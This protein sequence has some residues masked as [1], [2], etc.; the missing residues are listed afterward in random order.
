MGFFCNKIMCAD[1]TVLVTNNRNREDLEIHLFIAMNMAVEYC[2]MN[3]LVFSDTKEYN[4][5]NLGIMR[6]GVFIFPNIECIE[7]SK[8][9][10]IEI[11]R[12]L[13]WVEHL[14]SLCSKLSVTYLPLEEARTSDHSSRQDYFSTLFESHLRFGIVL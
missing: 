7:A 4:K 3:D 5:L 14:D 11:D 9:L 2:N 1:S 13:S 6:E 10:S 8:H 12:T